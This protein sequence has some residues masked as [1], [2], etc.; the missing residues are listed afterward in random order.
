MSLTPAPGESAFTRPKVYYNE[1]TLAP[2]ATLQIDQSQWTLSKRMLVDYI[3]IGD[4]TLTVNGPAPAGPVAL[5]S[6]AVLVG[7][8][9]LWWWISTRRESALRL[10]NA[11]DYLTLAEMKRWAVA[12]AGGIIAPAPVTFDGNIVWRFLQPWRYLPGCGLVV[13]WEYTLG[14]YV[15]A[16][17]PAVPVNVPMVD[18]ILYGVG[19]YTKHRRIFEMQMPAIN[20]TLVNQLRGSFTASEFVMNQTNEPYDIDTMM[21]RTQDSGA[22]NPTWQDARQLHMLRYTIRPTIGEPFS[23]VPIPICAFGIDVAPLRTVVYQPT[24]GPLLLEAGSTLGF[25]IQNTDPAIT[26]RAQVAMV[27]RVV[28]TGF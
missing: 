22:V 21:L 5:G 8:L 20:S 13:D 16:P 28:P 3:W 2:G 9:N 12:P 24:G 18:V 17:P 4:E 15:A 14:Q 1:V 26:V 19:A 11:V 27:G 10:R 6:Q 25:E 7:A 23:E